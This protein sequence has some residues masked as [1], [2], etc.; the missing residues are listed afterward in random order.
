MSGL[1]NLTVVWLDGNS[2]TDISALSGLIKI[3]EV[4]QD[5]WLDQREGIAICLGLSDNQIESIA[6][7]VDNEG[8]SVA[9]GIDLRGNALSTESLGTYLPQLEERGVNVLHD[10]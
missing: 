1:T 7:L 2:I 5:L 4:E 9:D 3:G 8:L 6:A 10:A